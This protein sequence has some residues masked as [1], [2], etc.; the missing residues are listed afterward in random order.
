MTELK[1]DTISNTATQKSSNDAQLQQVDTLIISNQDKVFDQILKLIEEKQYSWCKVSID[2]FHATSQC[3]DFI[4]TVIVETSDIPKAQREKICDIIRSLDSQSIGTILINNHI[5]FPVGNYDLVS[6]L[7]TGS[8]EELRGSLSSNIIYHKKLTK[9]DDIIEDS[10]VEDTEEQLKMAGHVQRDFLPESLPDNKYVKFASV[11][12]PADW[13]SGDIYDARR[14]D[15]QHIGFYIADAVGHSMPAALLT[16]FLKQALVMRETTGN[17]YRIYS[18]T[19]VISNLNKR[20][21]EQKL[22][23]SLFAT[24]C[25]CLL[26]IRT[27]QLQYAR[28]G[29]P[30]PILVDKNNKVKQ[31]QSRGSLLGVFENAEFIQETVQLNHGD[32]LFMYSDGAE[33]IIGKP[34]DDGQLVLHEDF[35]SIT[36]LSIDRMV[37]MFDVLVR[38]RTVSNVERDDITVLGLE[39]L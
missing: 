28:A 24:C 29:H 19:E 33:H 6:V 2:D 9:V 10:H 11:F 12:Q 21:V 14:L 26:N 27:M 38:N 8:I 32:R 31:L 18:P 16:M 34:Q 17:D 25:Y 36:E 22:S 4:G 3:Y 5:N 7:E 15:E 1:V 37:D 20:M 23:G 39:I 13:V 35:R 30:Y